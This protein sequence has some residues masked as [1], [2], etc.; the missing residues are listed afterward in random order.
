MSDMK[1]LVLRLGRVA[2]FLID[3]SIGRLC[4]AVSITRVRS[5]SIK[6]FADQSRFHRSAYILHGC[7]S[8]VLLVR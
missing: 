2:A 8:H 7:S 4:L 5:G 1:H 3:I 6:R